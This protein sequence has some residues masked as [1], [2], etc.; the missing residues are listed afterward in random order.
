MMYSLLLY[1]Q[2]GIIWSMP[3]TKS[4]SKLSLIAAYRECQYNIANN[5][6]HVNKVVILRD[7]GT[8][9][10]VYVRKGDKWIRLHELQIISNPHKQSKSCS[11]CNFYD[12]L[13]MEY[14][15]EIA[16]GKRKPS[17]STYSRGAV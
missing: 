4:I 17:F 9:V 8:A 14:T 15:A 6:D 7:D 2:K 11:F 10:L 5:S 13:W 1:R 16:A 3:F 12:Y